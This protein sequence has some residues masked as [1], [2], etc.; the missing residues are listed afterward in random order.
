MSEHFG[1]LNVHGKVIS[2]NISGC[3]LVIKTVDAD[4]IDVD[5]IVINGMPF[6]PANITGGGGIISGSCDCD[7]FDSQ[8]AAVSGA[9]DQNSTDIST[10]AGNI[11]TNTSNIGTNASNISTNS[12]NIAANSGSIGTNTTNISTNAA[13]IAVNASDIS[14]LQTQVDSITISAGGSLPMD[15]NSGLTTNFTVTETDREI[16]VGFDTT[17]GSRTVFM[18]ASPSE[19]DKVYIVDETMNAF[20]NNIT[21]DGNG[22]NVNCCPTYIL[23]YNN[24]GV[25]FVF[26]GGAWRAIRN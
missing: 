9:V 8:L 14:D 19:G 21:V 24:A 10:N 25:L 18:N 26:A 20:N 3:G 22:N 13:N 1:N 6:D 23:A 2:E 15:I 4:S 5:S 7:L 16:Y 11:S 17:S 12:G